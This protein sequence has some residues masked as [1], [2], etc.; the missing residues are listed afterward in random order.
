M[1]PLKKIEMMKNPNFSV[2]TVSVPSALEKELLFL[3]RK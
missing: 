2:L 3:R 1:L